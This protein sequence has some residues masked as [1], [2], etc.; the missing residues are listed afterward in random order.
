MTSR[1]GITQL[2]LERDIINVQAPDELNKSFS[3]MAEIELLNTRG[4]R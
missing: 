1:H 4:D 2:L 3:V